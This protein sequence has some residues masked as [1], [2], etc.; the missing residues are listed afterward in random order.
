MIQNS[1]SSRN[2]LLPL[3]ILWVAVLLVVLAMFALAI[4]ARFHQLSQDPYGFA[5]GLGELGLSVRAFAAYATIFDALVILAFILTGALIFWGKRGDRA[6]VLASLALLLMGISLV[7]LIP[8]LYQLNASWYV[9]VQ[10]VRITGLVM[11]INLMYVFPNGR[12]VPSWTRY[13]MLVVPF[14]ALF[15]LWPGW[16]PPTTLI[17][18]DQIADYL[19]FATLLLWLGTGA[20]A[21]IYRY[22]DVSVAVERQQTKWVVLGFAVTVIVFLA[23]LLPRALFPALHSGLNLV[24]YVLA[25]I[26]LALFALLFVPLSITISIFRYRLWDIDFIIRR[27]LVYTLLTGSLALVYFSSVVLLQTLVDSFVRG[28]TPLVTVVSTLAV[29]ALF[30]PLRRRIQNFIDRRFY[31]RK[32]DAGEVLATFTETLRDEVDLEHLTASILEVVDETM[33]PAHASLWL[34]PTK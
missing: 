17:D 30:T 26:P 20:Y 33:Q 12:F 27:T 24:L 8:S 28:K 15:L 19:A 29:A 23:L 7:P 21:Q 5:P 22:R 1:P 11:T 10:L 9:P 16:Q 14:A 34:K 4:P 31:R 18:I 32:Y 6:A 25:E 13:L 3:D 2:P